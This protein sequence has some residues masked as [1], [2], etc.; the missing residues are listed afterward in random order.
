VIKFDHPTER[1]LQS[2]LN[3]VAGF[4]GQVVSTGRKRAFLIQTDTI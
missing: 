2:T 4:P 1:N 3:G